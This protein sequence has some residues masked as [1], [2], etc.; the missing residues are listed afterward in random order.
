MLRGDEACVL[1]LEKPTSC[2]E[3]P[4]QPKKKKKC[5]QEEIKLYLFADGMINCVENSKKS[6]CTR[7][8]THTHTPETKK[9]VPQTHRMQDQ[10]TK[11]S[12]Y[13]LAM[14]K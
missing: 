14:N 8:H 3:D 11:V 9:W 6:T 1:Q 12:F 5:R 2:S 10:H 7:A 4:A 13:I